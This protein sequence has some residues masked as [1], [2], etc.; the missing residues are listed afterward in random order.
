MLNQTIYYKKHTNGLIRPTGNF[1]M[2]CP[3]E[4]K[5]IIVVKN[6]LIKIQ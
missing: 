4:R 1:S 6:Q 3:V 5:I 2:S